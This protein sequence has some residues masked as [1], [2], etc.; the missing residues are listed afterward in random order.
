MTSYESIDVHESR[1]GLSAGKVANR[2]IVLWIDGTVDYS[3]VSLGNDVNRIIDRWMLRYT[4]FKSTS[5]LAFTNHLYL[6]PTIPI[7]TCTDAVLRCCART[8][9]GNDSI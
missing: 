2:H 8:N 5:S 7:L 6:D 4:T 1:Y 9:L 3:Q